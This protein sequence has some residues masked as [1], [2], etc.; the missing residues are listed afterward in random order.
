[1]ND[2]A[3]IPY[4]TKEEVTEKVQKYLDQKNG[5]NILRMMSRAGN[6][7]DA[8]ATFAYEILAGGT[9][10]PVL[11]EMAILRVGYVSGS[12]YEVFHHEGMIRK[13]N[14]GEEKLKA[15]QDDIKSPL[16]SEAERI[17]LEITDQIIHH[18]KMDDRQFE[19][20]HAFLS[21]KDAMELVM[22][23]SFYMMACRFLE[24]YGIDLEEGKKK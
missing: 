10:D 7:A 21:Q 5:L 20:L 6:I 24:N 11:R 8:F 16:L 17:V 23:I 9:L 14:V 4:P 19:K 2:M 12:G 15:I 13:L 18:V 3:R 22:A 1:M